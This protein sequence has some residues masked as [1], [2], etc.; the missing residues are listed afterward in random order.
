MIDE[1]NGSG[2]VGIET[3]LQDIGARGTVDLL[4]GRDWTTTNTISIDGGLLNNQGGTFTATALDI[5]SGAVQG[6]GVIAAPV[7]NNATLMVEGGTLT[8][9]GA[10]TGTG[11]VAFDTDIKAGTVVATGAT[12][13]LGTVAA[14]QTI[15]MN[16]DDTLVVTNAAAFKGLILAGVGDAIILPGQTITSAIDTN[17]TL[18]LSNGGTVIADLLLA[19][20]FA[21]GR[22][23]RQWLHRHDRHRNRKPRHDH[24]VGRHARHRD[25]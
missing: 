17:G 6:N 3:T 5:N 19:G 21:A 23:D 16:G 9:A 20:S 25:R 4:R 2:Y 10:L 22:A 1:W 13:I 18:V 7:V 15:A 8:V 14:G 12:A 11:T 24:P